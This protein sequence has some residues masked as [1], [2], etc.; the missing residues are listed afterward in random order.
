M[1]GPLRHIILFR[2]HSKL[3]S[4]FNECTFLEQPQE[5][6]GSPLPGPLIFFFFLQ[7]KQ[8]LVF[9]SINVH[10]S[11]LGVPDYVSPLFLTHEE[12]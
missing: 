10:V 6:L 4:I 2:D 11:T 12:Y 5:V 3:P 7:R 9:I 8:V 1:S